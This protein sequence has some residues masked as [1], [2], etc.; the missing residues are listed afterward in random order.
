MHS[1]IEK[2]V[3]RDRSFFLQDGNLDGSLEQGCLVSML[4]VYALLGWQPVV[5]DLTRLTITHR[6]IESVKTVSN[7]FLKDCITAHLVALLDL[8][9]TIIWLIESMLPAPRSRRVQRVALVCLRLAILIE[10]KLPAPHL[11]RV[12]SSLFYF[13]LDS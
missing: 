11:R 8:Q 2:F 10:P 1:E 6:F 5:L 3:E 9:S 13:S 7:P 4:K 12:H